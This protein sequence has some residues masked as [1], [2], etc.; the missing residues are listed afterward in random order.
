MPSSSWQVRP[1]AISASSVAV[2]RLS[3]VLLVCLLAAVVLPVVT[4][5]SVTAAT[6]G[7]EADRLVAEAEL[8]LVATADVNVDTDAESSPSWLSQ[9]IGLFVVGALWGCTNPLLRRASLGLSMTT[10]PTTPT[11]TTTTTTTTAAAASSPPGAACCD[12]TS[13]H[14]FRSSA[15]QP[16][17]APP[18]PEI[19]LRPRGLLGEITYLLSRWQYV[20]PFLINQSGS[21]MFYLLLSQSDVSLVVPVANSL[22]F[23]FTTLTGA[24]LGE[25]FGGIGTLLGIACIV[26][27]VAI[28]MQTE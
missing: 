13:E 22:T 19:P 3:E 4:P 14:S 6:V 21:L 27:G 17:S 23:L 25:P 10:T 28:T 8:A 1:G 2:R 11:T 15:S 26:G 16:P 7:N 18:V 12:S 5:S 24:A 9:W 20:L